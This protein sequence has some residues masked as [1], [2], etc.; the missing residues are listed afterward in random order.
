MKQNWMLLA[1]LEVT[2]QSPSETTPRS[3]FVEGGIVDLF[4]EMFVSG[5]RDT[6]L[7]GCVVVVC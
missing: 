2:V 7:C 4:R 3:T 1:K 5:Q 6:L